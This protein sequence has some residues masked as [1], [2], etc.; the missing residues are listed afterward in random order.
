MDVAQTIR[1]LVV[2]TMNP[3]AKGLAI[4]PTYGNGPI[5]TALRSGFDCS[6]RLS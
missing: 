1:P 3:I 5:D 6:G 4:H 2:E